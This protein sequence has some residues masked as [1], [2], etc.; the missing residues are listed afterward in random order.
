MKLVTI[1]IP[2]YNRE[3]IINETIRSVICQKYRP[4]E[5]VVVDDCSDDDT[6]GI[7]ADI[8]GKNA[9]ND[10]SIKYLC[11]NM[12]SGVSYSRNI[13]LNN[14]SGEYIQYLDSDDLVGYDKISKQVEVLN[15]DC[16]VDIA[17]SSSYRFY[18]GLVSSKPYTGIGSNNPLYDIV[19]RHPLPWDTPGALYRRSLCDRVGL[20]NTELYCWEDW[21]YHVRMI[22]GARRIE[23]VSSSGTFIRC[24]THSQITNSEYSDKWIHAQ[25]DALRIV[26]NNV[27]R[28]C[29]KDYGIA[30]ALSLAFISCAINAAKMRNMKIFTDCMN[31]AYGYSI[32]RNI[33]VFCRII[34]SLNKYS[35]YLASRTLILANHMRSI[36]KRYI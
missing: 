27:C 32:S 31:D 9:D 36:K 7:I 14:A 6:K 1:I 30:D 22:L 25:Y 8:R 23:Y 18:E 4:I 33:R 35:S 10:V 11:N 29:C 24:T 13:G 34:R 17:Y 26:E 19:A 21:E 28:L 15:R 16:D 20:W 12:N 2:A 5:M 3:K